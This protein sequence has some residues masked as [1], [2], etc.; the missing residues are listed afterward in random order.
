MKKI[1]VKVAVWMFI[2]TLGMSSCIGSY[3]LFNKFAKWETQM[4]GNKYVNAIVGFIITPFVGSICLLGDSLIFNTIEFWSGSNPIADIGK[5]RT[6]MG[7]DGRY[8]AI[9]TLKNGYEI[10]APSGEVTNLIYNKKNN[11]W[12]MEQN[13]AVK[14]IFRFN[15]DGT[16]MATVN[17]ETHNYTLDEA[18]VYQA[19]MDANGGMFFAMR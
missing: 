18:G 8:Y 2:G 6:V 10:K 12:S 7:Q 1:N 15:N 16:I 3:S 4:T 5:T 17:G 9:T 14:E 11:S 19:R 13:G